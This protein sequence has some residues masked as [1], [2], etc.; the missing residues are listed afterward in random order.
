MA[1]LP[2]PSWK[3]SDKD[4]KVTE[5]W[6]GYL[7]AADDTWRPS[8]VTLTSLSTVSDPTAHVL[9]NSGVTHFNHAGTLTTGWILELPE[10]GQRKT[11][12]VVS[13][14]TTLVVSLP[15]TTARFRSG[16]SAEGWKLT[17][18][19]SLGY[20]VIDLIGVTTDRYYITS[21]PSVAVV[22]T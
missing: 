16:A 3:I 1:V 2:P 10:P 8:V 14:S 22:T 17:F 4:G 15:T 13:T 12:T 9:A 6:Y 20:K 21:N 11:I 19:S 5:P 18:P 7:K